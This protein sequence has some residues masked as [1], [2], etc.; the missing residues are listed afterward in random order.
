MPTRLLIFALLAAVAY[1][2]LRISGVDPALV[3]GVKPL[4][5]AALALGALRAR[6][7]LL[8]AALAS[9]AIGDVTIELG[10]ILAGIGPF[11]VGHL[12]YL[13]ALWPL[14]PRERGKTSPARIF[15]V[16]LLAGWA[17]FLVSLLLPRLD[18]A[19]AAAVPVYAAALLAMA[20][21]AAVSRTSWIVP[22]G[23]VLY[24]ASDSLLAIDA[25]VATNP[26]AQVAVWPTYV[27]GQVL[28]AVGILA[29]TRK[30]TG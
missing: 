4:A 30:P 18:G 8:G 14:L 24:V 2:L 15:L 20:S 28:L 11:L 16:A 25:F 17:G 3:V 19:L 27:G 9:H 22:L 23:A 6:H 29:A 7:F 5:V 26:A 1:P 13:A 10:G 21:A 12:L